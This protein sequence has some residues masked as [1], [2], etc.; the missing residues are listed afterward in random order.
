MIM[1]C[2]QWISSGETHL[3]NYRLAANSPV[4]YRQQTGPPTALPT[5][6]HRAQ[7]SRAS[8]TSRTT[9]RLPARFNSCTADHVADLLML[10]TSTRTSCWTFMNAPRSSMDSADDVSR[11]AVVMK[12]T[13]ASSA[14]RFIYRSSST[15]FCLSLA[16]K[17]F[18]SDAPVH[19]SNACRNGR[20]RH[21]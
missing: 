4:I 5:I 10:F 12:R 11:R 7:S 6:A 18:R 19:V 9:K 2:C 17:N 13:T 8:P 20:K 15:S 16:A 21:S 1:I 3:C 14:S